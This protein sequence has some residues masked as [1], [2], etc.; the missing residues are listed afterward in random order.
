M[1]QVRMKR[2]STGDT[3]DFIVCHHPSKYGGSEVSQ[4]RRMA[5][6]TSLAGL[7]D[8][9]GSTPKIVMGDF[10]DVPMSYTY[11]TVASKLNDTFSE[12]GNGYAHTYN[13]L[14]NLLRI[15]YIWVSKQFS[16]LSYEVLPTDLSDHY[17][18]ISRVILKKQ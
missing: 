3:L 2:I 7:C 12:K 9:L 4:A 6:M 8:S 10:N 14:F 13:G 18:V 15:D 5:A 16:T 17:P 1:L 11:R